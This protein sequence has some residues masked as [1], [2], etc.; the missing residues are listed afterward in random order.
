M[1]G[2]IGAGPTLPGTG[3]LGSAPEAFSVPRPGSP[4][5]SEQTQGPFAI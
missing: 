5:C 1:Q 4:T 3:R 2:L